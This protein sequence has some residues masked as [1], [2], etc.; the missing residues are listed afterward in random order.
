MV[1]EEENLFTNSEEFANV[2]GSKVKRY[3]PVIEKEN[4]RFIEAQSNDAVITGGCWRHF[5]WWGI[6]F[7]SKI[8]S[9]VGIRPV[10]ILSSLHIVM[11]TLNVMQFSIRIIASEINYTIDLVKSMHWENLMQKCQQLDEY[12]NIL[13]SLNNHDR[14]L[15]I[16]HSGFDNMKIFWRKFMRKARYFMTLNSNCLFERK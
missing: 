14:F 3:L 11:E 4:R 7:E 1:E 13:V 9:C 15:A 8:P 5:K 6:R 2:V 16:T 12:D 10:A